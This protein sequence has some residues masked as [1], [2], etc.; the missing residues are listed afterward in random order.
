MEFKLINQEHIQLNNLL[1]TLSLV[2]TGGEAKIRILEGEVFVNG[3]ECNVI[4]KKIF[5]GDVVEIG[6]M[7]I[8][9]KD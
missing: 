3:E 6:D 7:E 5:P 1:K 4:R 8:L 2:G 9:I